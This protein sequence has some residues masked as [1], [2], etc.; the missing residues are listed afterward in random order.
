MQTIG[1]LLAVAGVA[2]SITIFSM[3][4]IGVLDRFGRWFG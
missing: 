3:F 2:W 4:I 1:F